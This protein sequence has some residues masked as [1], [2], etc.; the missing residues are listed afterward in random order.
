MDLHW[1]I[2]YL[3]S[4]GKVTDARLSSVNSDLPQKDSKER[5]L[6]GLAEIGGCFTSK[7]CLSLVGYAGCYF[8]LCVRTPHSHSA[9]RQCLFPDAK[10]FTNH[11]WFTHLR[12]RFTRRTNGTLQSFSYAASYFCAAFSIHSAILTAL[13]F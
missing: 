3:R 11:T 7:P 8:F 12:I 6:M 1:S 5:Y 4:V 9:S 13:H 10:V 2:V